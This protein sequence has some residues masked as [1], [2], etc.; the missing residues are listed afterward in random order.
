MLNQEISMSKNGSQHPEVES[1]ESLTRRELEVAVA[2]SRGLTYAE[3][4]SQLSISYH[5]VNSHVKAI[6]A[7]TGLTSS[8]RLAVVVSEAVRRGKITD[9]SDVTE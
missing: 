6:L 8:R 7:K 9:S 2:I 1:L 5:T 4:A 3:I